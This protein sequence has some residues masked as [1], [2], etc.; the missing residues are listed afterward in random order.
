MLK[1]ENIVLRGRDDSIENTLKQLKLIALCIL[2]VN[3][4]TYIRDHVITYYYYKGSL[5]WKY[6]NLK[7]EIFIYI[8]TIKKNI[9]E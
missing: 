8:C 6:I 9:V 4:I 2:N 1:N 5:N 3:M 7:D